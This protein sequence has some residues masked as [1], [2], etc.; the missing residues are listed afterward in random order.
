MKVLL[1]CLCMMLYCG[2]A[3]FLSRADLGYFSVGKPTRIYPAT[4]MDGRGMWSVFTVGFE[5]DWYIDAPCR[6]L[7]LALLVVDTVP[8]VVIDTL[9]LPVDLTEK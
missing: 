8:S 5:D 6:P 3:T 1:V 2:C 9:M 4:A 7:C